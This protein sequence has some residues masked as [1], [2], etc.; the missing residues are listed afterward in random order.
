MVSLDQRPAARPRAADLSWPLVIGLA[1]R[2]VPAALSL[3]GE[4]WSS[5]AG[6]HGPLVIAT[7]VWLLW[8]QRSE[9]HTRGHPGNFWII[10]FALMLAL[11]MYIAGEAFDFITL[12][13][14]GLYIVALAMF[15]F[16]FGA[17]ELARN[18]F[19]FAYL[20]FAVPPPR[21]W[22]DMATFPL[23]QFV[24]SS[25]VALLQLCDLPVSH[26]GVV[27]YAGQYQFL[28]EDA[29]SGLNSILGL[30][31]ISLLYIY[32]ARRSSWRYAAVLAALTVPV[33]IVANIIRIILLILLTLWAGDAVAQGFMHF[34]AGIV[35]FV[36]ALGL[37]FLIDFGL[38]S[39]FSSRRA[40]A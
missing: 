14:L 36:I 1:A 23:K 4:T 37:I 9:L 28:V 16:L 6:A 15:C 2:G 29:C 39:F 18:W 17:K 5:D 12:E 33:A 30:I 22:L 7:A 31:A 3:S 8:R 20:L 13:A 21:S 27:I 11:G 26:Q 40:L 32:L 25:A 10:C 38:S 34:A 35:V 19:I 24:S